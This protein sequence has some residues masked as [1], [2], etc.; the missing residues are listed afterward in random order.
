M[1]APYFTFSDGPA[2]IERLDRLAADLRRFANGEL[3]RPEDLRDAPVLTQARI[4]NRPLPALAGNVCGHPGIDDGP[5]LTSQLMVLGGAGG[6]LQWAR[7]FS[8]YY[9]LVS[10]TGGELGR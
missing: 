7:T 3:P 6:D 8:R 9:R 2:M 10:I 5:V 4:C 1:M